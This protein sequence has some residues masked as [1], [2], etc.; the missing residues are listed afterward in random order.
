MKV[1]YVLEPDIRKKLA[2]ELE[3]VDKGISR[4]LVGSR[5]DHT[6]EPVLAVQVVLKD[7]VG[8]KKPSLKMGQRLSRIAA[9]FSRRAADLDVPWRA[10]VRFIV[11]SD[12][13]ASHK[14]A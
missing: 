4:V 8:L 10:S 7:S 11:E 12:L 6:G 3:S 5:F 9:E 1:S 14:P 2:A 13:V